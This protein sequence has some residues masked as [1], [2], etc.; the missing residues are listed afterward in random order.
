MILHLFQYLF[1]KEEE[2]NDLV[3][4]NLSFPTSFLYSAIAS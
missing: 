1:T 2:Q 3:T 4:L